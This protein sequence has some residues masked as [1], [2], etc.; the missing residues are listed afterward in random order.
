MSFKDK[1]TLV[2]LPA[3]LELLQ[4]S[5]CFMQ[6]PVKNVLSKQLIQQA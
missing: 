3:K 5:F 4:V 1:K 2:A 6:L